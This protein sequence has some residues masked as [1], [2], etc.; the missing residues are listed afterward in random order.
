MLL[1][2]VVSLSTDSSLVAPLMSH[3]VYLFQYKPVLLVMGGGTHKN[4]LTAALKSVFI[5]TCLLQLQ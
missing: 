1:K 3:F 2:I 4:A 5:C